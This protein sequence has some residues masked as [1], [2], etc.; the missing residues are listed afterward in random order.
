LIKSLHQREVGG[1]RGG[2]GAGGKKA[3]G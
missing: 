3:A 1:G 2:T